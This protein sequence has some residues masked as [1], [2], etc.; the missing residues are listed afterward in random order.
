VERKDGV[1]SSVEPSLFANAHDLVVGAK[2]SPDGAVRRTIWDLGCVL[3]G[4]IAFD[5]RGRQGDRLL[6]AFFEGME[7]GARPRFQWA[8]AGNNALT[9]HLSGGR[10]HFESFF[11]YGVRYIAVHE[12]G[13]PVDISGLRILKA[14]CSR[15]A[16]GTFQT[17]DPQING[18][19][20]ICEQTVESATDDTF[21]DCP[22]FEQVN[23]N[24]DNRMAALADQ[25]IGDNG[26]INRNSMQ[27]FAEDPH[28]RG[29][30]NSQTPSGWRTLIPMWSYHW[31]FWCRDYYW[32]TGD[33]AFL[34]RMLPTVRQGI[35]EAIGKIGRDGLVEF[36]GAWHFV[37][38]AQGRDDDHAINTVEQAA[39]L[40]VMEV[41]DRLA[42]VLGQAQE[43]A[44]ARANLRRAIRRHLWNPARRCFVDSRHE[45]GTPSKI[46][47]QV[48]NAVA[49]LYGAGDAAWSRRMAETLARGRSSLSPLGSPVG[50]FYIMELWDHFGFRAAIFK[51]IRQRWGAMLAAG[52]GTTWETFAEFGHGSWPTRSRCHPYSAYVVK[53]LVKYILGLE[54][55]AP[56]FAQV[57]IKPL[58]PEGMNE[59][60][61][62]IP[63]PHGPLRI[64]WTR[65]AGK[66]DLDL[67]APRGVKVL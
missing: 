24:F 2:V 63:T 41:A 12:I 33:V 37:E 38:W 14:T 25:L 54:I 52:D 11:P 16:P 67:E 65:R 60:S 61:G 57:R 42:S 3:N 64:S 1:P 26:A 36:P 50:L 53:Y 62:T 49:A 17:D 15:K 48:S 56:G 66:I 46:S 34:R 47:S 51:A 7:N 43:F 39:L 22:T 18:V 20:R 31:I 40:E 13:G 21:T 6:L 10:Q 55:I 58:P 59:A 8:N 28:C 9:Y 32:H 5:A 19:Y 35:R 30:V 29:L 44:L 23:W 45:D 27:L 4:W